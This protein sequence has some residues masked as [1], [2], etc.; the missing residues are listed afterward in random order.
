LTKDEILDV[1]QR[2]RILNFAVLSLELIDIQN[3]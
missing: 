3:I 2:K 1:T